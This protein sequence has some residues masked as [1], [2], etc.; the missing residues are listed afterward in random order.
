MIISWNDTPSVSHRGLITRDVYRLMTQSLGNLPCSYNISFP[1]TLLVCNTGSGYVSPGCTRTEQRCTELPPPPPKLGL[2]LVPC[3]W[4]GR[5][6]AT[7]CSSKNNL[8]WDLIRLTRIS[9]T[10]LCSPIRPKIEAPPVSV[11]WWAEIIGLHHQAHGFVICWLVC[12]LG[13]P[14]MYRMYSE[15]L[16]HQPSLI[17]HPYTPLP[18]VINSAG[19]ICRLMTF[20]LAW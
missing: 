6:P 7:A 18:P 10:S 5:V 1:V 14:Y 16:V 19:P 4:Y 12:S 11:F 20:G 17:C 13:I 9:L 15:Y 2:K 3:A 8:R